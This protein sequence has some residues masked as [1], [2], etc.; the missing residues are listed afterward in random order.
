MIVISGE[1]QEEFRK[2]SGRVEEEMGK[3]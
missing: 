3:W 2:S 1:V